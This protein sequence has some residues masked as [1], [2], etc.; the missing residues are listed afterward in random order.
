MKAAE[1]IKERFGDLTVIQK[2]AIPKI[3]EGR[4]VLILAPTGYGKTEAALLP[5]LEKIKPGDRGICA[6]YI[7]PLRSLNRDLLSRFHYWCDKL[8]VSRVVRHGDTPQ[9][10]RAKH[11][12]TPPHIMLTTVESIQALLR[13]KIMRQHLSNVR[14][15]IVD[16]VHDIVDNKRGAQLSLGLER[17]A[18]IAEFKRIGI[19]ATVANEVEVGKLLFGEREYTVVEAGKK[20]KMDITVKYFRDQ[21]KRLHRIKELAEKHRS[22]VFVNTRSAAEE[23]GAWLKKHDA[24][25]EV[26]HG[27]LS[28]DVRIAAED[29]FKSGE[30]KSLICTSSLELGIDIGDAELVVQYGSPH[31]VFRLVQRIGRSGHSITKLPRGIILA[32]DFDDE[33]ESEVVKS[34]AENGWIES[35]KVEKGSLDVIAH[36]LVGLALDFWG[37]ELSDAHRILSRSGVYGISYEKLRKIALQLYSEGILFYDESDDGKRI[38]IKPKRRAR[39]YYFSNL[40]TIPRVKRYL[41]KDVSSNRPIASLDEEFVINL[42]EGAEFLSKGQ[43]WQVADIT[44]EEVLASPGGG[45]DIAIPSWTGEE[46]PVPYEVAQ[47]AGSLRKMK[48]RLKPMPD[49]KTMVIEIVKDLIIIHACFGRRVNEG[50]ARLFAYRLSELIGESVRTVSDPYRIMIKLPFALSQKHV[51]KAFEGIRNIRQ[52]LEGSVHNSFLMRFVFT[53]VGRLFGLLSEDA[54]INQRFIDSMRYSVVYEESLRYIFLRYF[55]VEK[56]EG[57]FRKLKSGEIKLVVD[58]REEP[59]FFADIGIQRAS[60]REAVGGFEPRERMIMALK[61]YVLSKTLSMVCLNCGATRY[62]YLAT[63]KD[64]DAKCPRCGKS[65]LA[66]AVGTEQER[67]YAADLIRS[68]GKRALIALSVYGIGPSTAAR[69]LRR[70]HKDDDAFYF[71]LMEAQKAFVKTKKYWKI[72]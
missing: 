70:L 62:I 13:G 59:S 60:A 61:E 34:L 12:K 22:L 9:S 37:L 24:P 21:E 36:Q 33:L 35:K 26:H 64:S 43:V 15:V 44:D 65:S 56:T 38:K 58:V 50:I 71:D 27:S 42:D 30:T 67:R 20:R 57:I 17:L 31:Q 3:A 47:N 1:L 45:F 5:V 11:R 53:H 7:T 4:N 52:E 25:V 49:D 8:G 39:D 48:K 68:Y 28:R 14:Y 10:E 40:S 18:E 63:A 55:D 23:I 69:I 2:E 6:L 32:T 46:I 19:S 16:E 29:R 54:S 41:L 51:L 66:P 72:K